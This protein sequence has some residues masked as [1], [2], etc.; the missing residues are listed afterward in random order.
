MVSMYPEEQS[1]RAAL[2]AGANG[3]VAKDA[4]PGDLPAA[5]R[6]VAPE[7]QLRTGALCDAAR[8]AGL[9]LKASVNPQMTQIDA[10]KTTK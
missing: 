10:V 6:L 3:Y 4:E 9:S 2:D 8:A 1:A 7:R 5:I